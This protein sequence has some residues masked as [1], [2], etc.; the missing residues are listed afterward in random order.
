MDTK[1]SKEVSCEEQALLAASAQSQSEEE[2]ETFF[3]ACLKIA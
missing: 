1:G 3:K 2:I